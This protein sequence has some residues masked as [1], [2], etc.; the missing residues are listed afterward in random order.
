M[1]TPQDA[2]ADIDDACDSDEP[3]SL[4]KPPPSTHYFAFYQD[5]GRWAWRRVNPA[6]S[7]VESSTGGFTR[8]LQCV[9]DAKNHGWKGKPL[10]VL[11]TLDRAMH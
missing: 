9:A 6:G 8:Y 3:G 11:S 4:T 2:R 1:R 7:V 10:R 5:N